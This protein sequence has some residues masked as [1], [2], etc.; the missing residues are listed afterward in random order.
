[1]N[2]HFPLLETLLTTFPLAVFTNCDTGMFRFLGCL[3]SM[4]A[5]RFPVISR[6]ICLAITV[7]SGS[8]GMIFTDQILDNELGYKLFKN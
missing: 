3:A 2:I 4:S 5:M 1:M 8:S 6:F 7:I